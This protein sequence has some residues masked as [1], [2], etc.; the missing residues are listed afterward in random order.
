VRILRFKEREQTGGATRLGDD[1]GRGKIRCPKCAWQPG[2]HDRWMC[3]CLHVW[4]TFDTHGVCP[5][6]NHAW[7]D[8]ACLRCHQWS[9]HADWYV[10][11]AT[12]R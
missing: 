2:K 9:P 10:D 7:R 1:A 11:G 3:R 6:C 5:A 4:N 8:T 12:T